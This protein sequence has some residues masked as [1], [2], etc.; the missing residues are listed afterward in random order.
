M[1]S[2]VLLIGLLTAFTWGYAE[3]CRW[4][5]GNTHTHTDRSDGD[6][7]PRRVAAWY[8]DHDYHFL[9]ITDHDAITPID[10]IDTDDKDDFLLISGEEITDAWGKKRLHV[11]ALR[12][13]RAV[14]PGRG[15]GVAVNL[16]KN[17]DS[18][19]RVGA[20]PQVNHPNWRWSITTDDLAQLKNVT[21]FEVYNATR[22]SNNTGGGGVPGTEEMWDA[23]LSRGVVLY[24]VASDDTHNYVGE[25][26]PNKGYP[27]YGWVM[28]RAAA[29]TPEA[30]CAALEKGDFYASNGVVLSDLQVDERS[31]R[32]TAKP[33]DDEKFTISFI[34]RDGKVLQRDNGPAAVYTF[35]G[36][37]LY[38]RVKIVNS[39]GEF[40]LTQ[41]VFPARRATGK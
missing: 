16:Q 25:F 23:V 19:R 7:T 39:R 41:P 15:E 17:I 8:R 32:V 34:G 22:D 2:I 27:G 14:E 11:C 31:Y 33:L 38:V 9:F 30:I 28:V 5:K 6:E 36:D 1:K 12:P 10:A 4:Y 37:E 20:V 35:R 26:G 29:L 18:A 3:E 24:G 21:L 40:A 13:Q